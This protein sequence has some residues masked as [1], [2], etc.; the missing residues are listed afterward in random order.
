MSN[1]L[2]AVIEST[3]STVDQ[4]GGRLQRFLATT[5]WKESLVIWLD[6]PSG[7]AAPDRRALRGRLTADIA[8]I[9]EILGRQVDAIVHRRAFQ[10]LEASWR[11]LEYLTGNL[12]EEENVKIR[13]LSLGWKELARDMERAIEFDQSQLFRLVYGAEFGTAGG[14]PFAVLLGDY[15]IRH[16][17]GP[18]HPVDDLETLRSISQ[19]SA[20]AFA[21]FIASAHPA[22]FGLDRWGDLERPIDLGRVFEQVEYTKWN[23]L[24]R[25]EESRFVGL[26]LPRMLMRAPW[27]DDPYRA[28]GFR[29]REEIGDSRGGDHLWGSAVFAFGAVLLRA[30]C[31]CGWLAGIRG[32]DRGVFSGGL[33]PHHPVDYFETD[34]PGLVPKGSVEVIVTDAREKELGDHGFI[35]LCQTHSSELCAFYGN[36]SIQQPKA[37]A[38]PVATVNAKLSAMLQYMFCVSRFAHYLKVIG[39]DRLGSF[40]TPEECERFMNKWLMDFATSNENV[41]EEVQARYPLREAGVKVREV[42][43]KPGVYMSVIHLRPHFQLDQLTS[44]VKL[45]TELFTNQDL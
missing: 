6:L 11:G 19:V 22:F 23:A 20:A 43:G 26:T 32:V 27:G 1:L 45:V 13:V 44:S 18:D 4:A 34:A 33:V 39:R 40:A 28:D 15:E 29:Y 31:E 12:E 35:P 7:E 5:S 17:L 42:P 36:Q 24:R 37:Y 10:R 21:P 3:K 30:F 8:A 9:D 41:S 25:A 2:S 16:R 14:E 38:N